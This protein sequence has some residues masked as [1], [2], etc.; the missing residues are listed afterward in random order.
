M[1]LILFEFSYV[2]TLFFFFRFLYG[3]TQELIVLFFLGLETLVC[4]T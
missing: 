4:D 2:F 1:I 3:F